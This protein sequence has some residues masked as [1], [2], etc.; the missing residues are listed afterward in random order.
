MGPPVLPVSLSSSGDAISFEETFLAK[1]IHRFPKEYRGKSRQPVNS[2][3][4]VAFANPDKARFLSAIKPAIFERGSS[5]FLNDL[6]HPR[7][8]LF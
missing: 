5:R 4:V 1:R 7:A 2:R 3:R 6:I 8:R